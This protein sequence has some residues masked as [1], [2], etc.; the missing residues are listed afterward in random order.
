MPTITY[1]PNAVPP[2]VY[3]PA[4]Y[5]WVYGSSTVP[6]GQSIHTVKWQPGTPPGILVPIQWL[7]TDIF[8][9]TETASS[10]GASTLQITRSTSAGPFVAMNNINDVVV[11]IPINLNQNV[12][13]PYTASTITHP[14]V[15][16][17]D[18]LQSVIT[19]A[20]GTSNI[21]FFVTLVQY[22]GS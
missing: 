22:Q 10:A 4:S 6:A 9:R 13:R 14:L 17:G 20:A 3:P 19:L 2:G 15:N 12:G 18:K 21:S 11:T 7:I 8:F 5:N 16:S 1:F